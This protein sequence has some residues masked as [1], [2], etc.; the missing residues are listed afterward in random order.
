[1]SKLARLLLLHMKLTAAAGKE[2][3]GAL[4]TLK[5]CMNW[6]YFANFVI[7]SENFHDF[8]VKV[9]KTTNPQREDYIAQIT[10]VVG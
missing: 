2:K 3:G 6:V 10:N 4:D 7:I 8:K 5:V 1:M 9:L